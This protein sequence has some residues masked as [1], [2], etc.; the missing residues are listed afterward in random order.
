M[1]ISRFPNRQWFSLNEDSCTFTFDIYESPQP[2]R[3]PTEFDIVASVAGITVIE[4]N[5]V[6]KVPLAGIL[7]RPQSKTFTLK[8]NNNAFTGL[9]CT[10]K[11]Q[12][13]SNSPIQDPAIVN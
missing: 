5:I 1:D 11:I 10:V 2:L 6:S 7:S 8:A 4:E 13:I 3:I 12:R 9:E